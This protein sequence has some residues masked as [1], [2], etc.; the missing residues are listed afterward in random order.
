MNFTKDLAFGNAYERKLIETLPSE[1][2]LIKEGYF[3]HYDVEI[4][5]KGIPSKYEVKADRYT[6]KTN[7]IAIEFECN[8]KPSGINNTQSDFYAYYVVR[9]NGDDDLFIIP[10]KEIQVRIIE[11]SYKK[12]VVGGNNNK[13]KMYMFD[14]KGFLGY[15]YKT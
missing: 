4:I 1:S 3:P 14:I 10:T 6:H 7:N 2:Y 13:S 8:G 5:N 11:E 15:R 9:P 12:I